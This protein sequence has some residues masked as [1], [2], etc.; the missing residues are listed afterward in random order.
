ML[1]RI[2]EEQLVG[3]GGSRTPKLGNYKNYLLKFIHQIFSEHLLSR[4]WNRA[5]K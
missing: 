3:E 1:R 5:A 2:N 4:H